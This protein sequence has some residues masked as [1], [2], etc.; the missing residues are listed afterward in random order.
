LLKGNL[1]YYKINKIFAGS[2]NSGLISENGELLLQGMN[3]Q[4]QLAVGEELGKNLY[5]FPEFMKK[6]FFSTR[7]LQVIDV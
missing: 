3:D 2:G 5:F 7:G 6:D 4:N 1:I